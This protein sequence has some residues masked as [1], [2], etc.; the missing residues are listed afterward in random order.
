[1]RRNFR[2][3][4]D[5][6]VLMYCI[7]AGLILTVIVFALLMY[8]ISINN[9]V[10]NSQL[11][12][13]QIAS[14]LN[15]DENADNQEVE[16]TSN[17]LGKSIEEV[18]IDLSNK[19]E[20]MSKV[21]NEDNNEK[22]SDEKDDVNN[23]TNTKTSEYK[24]ESN[25]TDE[26]EDN[27]ET[28]ETSAKATKQEEKKDL[29]F[30]M[31]V[32]GD[33]VKEFAKDNLVYSDTLKEWV[34]H[35]GIDIKAEKTTVVNASEAGTI[36]SIKNDPRYG[37]TIVIDHENGY[38]TVYANLLSSEFVKTGE[39][40]EKGQAIGTVGNTGVFESADEPHLHFEILKD[41]IA[42]D[43]NIYIR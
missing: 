12:S 4:Q 41:S 8:S 2:K 24:T 32:E 7:G 17:T 5:N 3:K 15:N 42:L 22:Q 25:K 29:V 13:N 27:F 6:K 16:R 39:K 31:P 28:S 19:M 26:E 30:G 1:M 10:R 33:I 35:L 9:D 43:P 11:D 14:I 38:Q 20:S 40:V 37:L 34:T 36:K 21:N 23:Q 18:E